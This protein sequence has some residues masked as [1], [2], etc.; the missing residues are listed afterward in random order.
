MKKLFAAVCI[1][2]LALASCN[3]ESGSVAVT[4]VSV[5]PSSLT[6]SVG[7]TY[8][9][10]AT[11]S[12]SDAT[13]RSVIWSSNDVGVA[14]VLNGTVAAVAPGN[15]TIIATSVDGGQNR[16]LLGLSQGK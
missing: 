13:N 9:L 15:T 7:E 6:L 10:A 11:V 5:S 2:S 14:T 16:D 4:G 3:P 12:P 8:V 1:F